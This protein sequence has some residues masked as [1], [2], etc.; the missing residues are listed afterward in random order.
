M[1]D[2]SNSPHILIIGAGLAG[3]A[4]AQSL[5]ARNYTFQVFDRDVS[6]V[7]RNQGWCITLH[8]EYECPACE[9]TDGEL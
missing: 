8:G 5:R 2:N 3:L 4:L 7:A 9:F 6:E 1:A